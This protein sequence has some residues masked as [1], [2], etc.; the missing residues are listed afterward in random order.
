MSQAER[1][2]EIEQEGRYSTLAHD[3]P[4]FMGGLSRMMVQFAE[5]TR[6]GRL[7]VPAI[8]VPMAAIHKSMDWTPW[9]F[10]RWRLAKSTGRASVTG[11]LLNRV[12]ALQEA[13]KHFMKVEEGRQ[14]TAVPIEALRLKAIYGTGIT[15]LITAL[16]W[17]AIDD[18]DHK[19]QF[20]ITAQGPRDPEEK[21]QWRQRGFQPYS[22]RVRGRDYSYRESPIF[23][24]LLPIGALSDAKRYDNGKHWE[25]MPSRFAATTTMTARAMTDQVALESMAQLLGV[26]SAGSSGYGGQEEQ[27][28][29]KALGRVA[30]SA[31]FPNFGR[32]LNDILYGPQ[33]SKA[34]SWAAAMFQN[35]PFVP[36]LENRPAINALGDVIH[37]QR[38]GVGGEIVNSLAYR[39]ATKP[40]NDPKLHFLAKMDL[41]KLFTGR[42]KMD[43]TLVMDDYPLYREWAIRSGKALREALTDEVISDFEK[44]LKSDKG[45]ALKDFDKF[46]SAIRKEALDDLLNEKDQ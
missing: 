31:A 2:E 6:V 39:L 7:F 40:V 33:D 21:R 44:E 18:D 14:L 13:N 8:R 37:E 1:I 32:E 30:G 26:M 19:A 24:A 15:T 9:G 41:G 20:Y 45:Q 11:N 4:G 16:I 5:F 46:V 43:G 17:S 3:V 34:R 10:L 28:L 22:I 27:V 12:P 38:G 35:V 29:K 23:A 25:D 36:S 42:R